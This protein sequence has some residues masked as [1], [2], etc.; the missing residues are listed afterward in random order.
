[1]PRPNNQILLIDADSRHAKAFGEALV[2][3]GDRRTTFE[4]V[5]TLSSGLEILARKE[6]WAVFLNLSLPDS[7]GVESLDRLLLDT[8]AVPVVVIA[9]V[10]DEDLCKTAMLHGARDY[11]LEGHLDSYAFARV[12]RNVTEREIARYELFIEKE[13]A[14]VT[15]NSIGDAV[16]STDIAGN[17]THLNSVAEHTDWV[18]LQGRSWSCAH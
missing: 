6:I 18:V 13:R 5:R 2:A 14:Q 16:L 1:M 8:P 11:L 3:T 9:G 4:R 15:L 17:I 10:D 7:W 12:I